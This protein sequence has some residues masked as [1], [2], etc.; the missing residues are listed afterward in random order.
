MSIG[1]HNK[2]IIYVNQSN[3]LNVTSEFKQC[4][5]EIL[6]P[7][8]YPP[9]N[10]ETT[11]YK[12]NSE[13]STSIINFI[14]NLSSTIIPFPI[15][16]AVRMN[17]LISI[18]HCEFNHDGKRMAVCFPDN[19]IHI[20]NMQK[21]EWT[22]RRLFHE[23]IKDIQSLSWKSD[24]RNTLAVGCLTGAYIFT[25]SDCVY[26]RRICEKSHVL[27]AQYSPCGQ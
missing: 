24:S 17:R 21:Q 2:R 20:Y 14:R 6:N 1:E 10:K 7:M 23:D 26:F 11:V 5:G 18:Q 25:F 19:S 4:G 16:D 13:S 27:S 3:E 12:Q 9:V 8:Y 15:S 22:D